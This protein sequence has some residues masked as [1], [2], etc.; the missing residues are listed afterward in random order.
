MTTKNKT[1]DPHNREFRWRNKEPI[2]KEEV[3]EIVKQIRHL[4][5]KNKDLVKIEFEDAENNN[6]EFNINFNAS[7]E[8]EEYETFT[9]YSLFHRNPTELLAEE[10]CEDNENKIG[11]NGVISINGNLRGGNSCDTFNYPY[12]KVVK[13]ALTLMQKITK[14]KFEIKQGNKLITSEG[15]K[16][17]T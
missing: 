2:T 6:N 17:E 1:Q 8:K 10:L 15:I 11:Y 14:D 5:E 3:Q 12:T 13:K 4:V 9:F 16:N 7:N